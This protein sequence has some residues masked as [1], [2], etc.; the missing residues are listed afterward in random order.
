MKVF[1]DT[2]PF[3]YYLEDSEKFGG[4]VEELFEE[5]Q[6][7]GAT[8]ITSVISQMEY[9]VQP[10]RQEKGILVDQ[11]LELLNDLSI[12]VFPIDRGIA[13]QAARLRAKYQSLKGMDALQIATA[14]EC[15][16]H[17]FY[18]N[19]KKLGQIKEV[20]IVVLSQAD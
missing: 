19:D 8:L 11:F 9:S 15:G 16:C 13:E 20:G 12:Q 10:Y 17:I 14:I 3:I 6:S 4:Q 1:F 2:A 18:T 7:S 5:Y